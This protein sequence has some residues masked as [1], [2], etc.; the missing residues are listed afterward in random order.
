M[1]RTTLTPVNIAGGSSAQLAFTQFSLT[2]GDAVNLNQFASTGK[3]MLVVYNSGAVSPGVSR[4]VT[5]RHPKGG[6]IEKTVAQGQYWISGQFPTA[7]RQS[8]DNM[9]YVDPEANSNN[10]TDLQFAVL[11]LP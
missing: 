5:I 11:V 9:I 10:T 3:E 2:T 1:P 8:G 4:K 7:W 6:S